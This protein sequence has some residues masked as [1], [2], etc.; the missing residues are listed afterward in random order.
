M[1]TAGSECAAEGEGQE[2]MESSALARERAG[3]EGMDFHGGGKYG[4]RA[5]VAA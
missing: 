2:V 5:P 4:P 1:A 3:A